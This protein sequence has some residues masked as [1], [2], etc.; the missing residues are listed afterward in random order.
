MVQIDP[1][2]SFAQGV[3]LRN[4]MNQQRANVQAAQGLASG[5]YAQALGALGGVGDIANVLKVQEAQVNNQKA[6]RE[7]QA[8]DTARQIPHRAA[9]ERER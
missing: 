1:F 6:A 2:G 3:S 8:A 9:M 5:N 7:T 4:N